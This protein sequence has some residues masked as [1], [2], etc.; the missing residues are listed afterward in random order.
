MH[1]R[2]W[3]LQ[4]RT[5]A[6]GRYRHGVESHGCDRRL[7]TSGSRQS[8]SRCRDPR[9][10]GSNR[11]PTSPRARTSEHDT[12]HIRR[13]ALADSADAHRPA[14]EWAFSDEHRSWPPCLPQ[15][16]VSRA[17]VSTVQA[18]AASLVPNPLV[19]VQPVAPRHP[20]VD[21]NRRL[22]CGRRLPAVGVA[23]PQHVQVRDRS[24]GRRTAEPPASRG[25]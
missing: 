8:S 22:L 2:S 3:I 17:L 1:R 16:E 12:S 18:T 11:G 9:S 5:G 23:T 13:V 25:A 24:L 21:R 15:A 20:Q 10:T 4:G 19:L 6:G 14:S 7:R